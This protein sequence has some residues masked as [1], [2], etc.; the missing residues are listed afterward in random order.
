MKT[1][2]Y[3]LMASLVSATGCGPRNDESG[4]VQ[5]KNVCSGPRYV[6]KEQLVAD[7][8]YA[9]AARD[10]WYWNR[11]DNNLTCAEMHQAERSYFWVVLIVG[12]SGEALF[13]SYDEAVEWTGSRP[14][15][16]NPK[17]VR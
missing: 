15:V 2:H 11:R 12:T 1:R 10:E 7:G 6:T 14:F 16:Q 4:R 5:L 17:Q 13:S 9:G 8:V 3:L